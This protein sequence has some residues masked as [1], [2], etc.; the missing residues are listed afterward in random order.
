MDLKV[1]SPVFAPQ[2]AFPIK[3]LPRAVGFFEG[4]LQRI[5][6][7]LVPAPPFEREPPAQQV[8]IAPAIP[9]TLLKAEVDALPA[10]QRLVESGQFLVQYARARQIPWCLQEIGRLR[11]LSFRAA[12]EGTGRASDIDLFDAYYLH[13][14]VWDTQAGAI[15]GAYRMGLADEILERYGKRGLY[16]HSLFKYGARLLEPLNPAIELGRSF[17][18]MEYQRSFSALLLLW[19]GIGRFVLRSPRYAVLFGPVSISN[20]YAPLSRQLMVEYLKTNNTEAELARHVRARRPFRRQQ[21]RLLDE[22]EFANLKD[23]EDLSHLIARIEG[24]NKGVPILLRQYLK[25]GG[26]LLGF[27]AD[28]RFSDALDGLIMVDLRASDPR[29]LSRYM[30]G[31]GAATFLARHCSDPDS[32][33]QAS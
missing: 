31:E 32:L 17:V 23:I 11:E 28:H 16:T 27:N 25:L 12:G 8:P 7:G 24:D 21:S 10:E 22:V 20:S 5:L 19:R 2:G 4:S 29:V 26:R 15:V 30:G 14:F 9:K 1:V 6:S 33:R 18:R 3:P 13:L